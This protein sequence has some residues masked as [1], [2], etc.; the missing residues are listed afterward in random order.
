MFFSSYL[1]CCG[2]WCVYSS[3]DK[4]YLRQFSSLVR[5]QMIL[6]NVV[7]CFIIRQTAHHQHVRSNVTQ[8][9]L[10]R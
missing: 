6:S 9:T 10:C 5:E 7:Q 3:L 1:P 2:L 8:Q 4:L